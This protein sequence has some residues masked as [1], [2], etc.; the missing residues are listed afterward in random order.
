MPHDLLERAIVDSSETVRNAIFRVRLDRE[1]ALFQVVGEFQHADVL[2]HLSDFEHHEVDGVVADRLQAG[3]HRLFQ[4][5]ILALLQETA[6]TA[7]WSFCRE[8]GEQAPR[9]RVIFVEVREIVF[10]QR[11]QE[12]GIE[13]ATLVD[14]LSHRIIGEF[15]EGARVSVENRLSR[16]VRVDA[17]EI[18]IGWRLVEHLARFGEGARCDGKIALARREDAPERS[19]RNGLVA[20]RDGQRGFDFRRILAHYAVRVL[21][22]RFT[23]PASKARA[24]LLRARNV[25]IVGRD[26]FERFVVRRGFANAC[27]VGIELAIVTARRLDLLRI[28][29]DI[30]RLAVRVWKFQAVIAFALKL[31]DSE[32]V[33]LLP[34]RRLLDR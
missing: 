22:L 20:L 18:D 6:I 9:L 5:R 14:T 34:P 19:T 32:F 30:C 29:C 28:K 11:R 8:C 16:L 4:G 2:V 15:E 33:V 21:A 13:L 24:F 17:G 27:A 7:E 31:V 23:R 10:G 12:I 3:R 25:G 1:P 26:G